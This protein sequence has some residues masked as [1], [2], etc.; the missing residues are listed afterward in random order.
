MHVYKEMYGWMCKEGRGDCATCS[1]A[2]MHTIHIKFYTKYIFKTY[3]AKILYIIRS[4][5]LT[6]NKITTKLNLTG[7]YKN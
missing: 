2:D 5:F 4:I 1:D 3:L 7:I 6:L